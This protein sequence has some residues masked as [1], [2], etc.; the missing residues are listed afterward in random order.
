MSGRRAVFLDRDGTIIEDSGFIRDPAAVR[1]L[2]GAAAAIRALRQAGYLAV[3][4]TNQSGIARGILTEPDYHR[5]AERMEA[6]LA[7]EGTEVD[8]TYM[9]PHYPPL[10][11]PCECRKPGTL[12]YR[13]AAERFGLDL[14]NCWWIGDRVTDVEPAATLG[15]KG[16]LLE[17]DVD[18]RAATERILPDSGG[19]TAESGAQ[20]GDHP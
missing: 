8:A 7:A 9:C 13:Q 12:H 17:G 3:V 1:L 18:L 14:A 10:S 2:P 15:G 11:G 4:V 20:H 5:V 6:L 19:R 16:I